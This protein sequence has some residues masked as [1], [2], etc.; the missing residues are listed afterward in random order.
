MS[1][2]PRPVTATFKPKSMAPPVGVRTRSY[3]LSSGS[4]T[5]S[6]VSVLGHDSYE[7]LSDVSDEEVA[8]SDSKVSFS[9]S[10]MK[11]PRNIKVTKPQ[12]SANDI[13]PMGRQ[14]WKEW[15]ITKAKE[16]REKQRREEMR[17]MRQKQ[18]ER[19]KERE[20]EEKL[21]RARE[22]IKEWM[23]AKEL[24]EKLQKKMSVHREK[25]K[26]MIEEEKKRELQTKAEKKYQDW[27]EQKKEAEKEQK[28][29]ER[30]KKKQEEKE[31]E[32]KERK[33]REAY[34]EWLKKARKRPKSAQSSLGYTC[35]KLTGYYDTCTYP[36]PSF[37]NPLPWQ[38]V[39]MPKQKPE[40]KRSR[41]A[42]RK[43]WN[44]DRY[45]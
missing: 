24:T 1:A 6:L 31:R 29:R 43:R 2:R 3:S 39:E 41:S 9:D 16:L 26:S 34:E 23:E 30:E 28:R 8:P 20:K 18:E 7:S 14:A 17:L 32:E 12:E 25:S 36:M 27:K 5:E 45:F 13:K 42:P 37:I 35:G 33:S 15:M 40:K 10:Q 19:K 38:P 4:S 22:K 21:Q 44:P 11:S